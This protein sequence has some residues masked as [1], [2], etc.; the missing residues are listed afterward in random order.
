MKIDNEFKNLISPLTSE[1]FEIL[2]KNI[3]ERGIQDSIK[4]WQGIIID[5]HNRYEIALRHNI[6]Y[7]TTDLC[8]ESRQSVIEWILNNQLGRRNLSAYD[9]SLIALKLEDMYKLK[10]LENLSLAG[11]GLETLPKVNTREEIAE[12]AKVS[13]KTLD[14]VKHIE[15][16][17][18]P[19]VLTK[20]IEGWGDYL[21]YGFSNEKEDNLIYWK[22]IDLNKFR[23]FFNRFL[24]KNKGEIPGKKQQNGDNSSYFYS[25]IDKNEFIFNRKV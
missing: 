23:L 10:G 25:F 12:K 6:H 11:K 1:E 16:K 15:K 22:M 5:G 4:V 9:R 8:F 19:E 3:L 14:K 17:A 21:F 24:V 7:D 20:I 2:E 18:A 13:G